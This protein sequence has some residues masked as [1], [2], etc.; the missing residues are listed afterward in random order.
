MRRFFTACVALVLGVLASCDEPTSPVRL[1]P[2][3]RSQSAY[4][5]PAS[6]LTSPPQRD[7]QS[8]TVDATRTGKMYHR[9]GCR[10]LSRRGIPMSLTDAERSYG[11]CSVCRPPLPGHAGSGRR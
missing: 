9:D 2:D 7:P 11:P 10:Y 4:S 6:P 8:I 3:G 5:E 1:R